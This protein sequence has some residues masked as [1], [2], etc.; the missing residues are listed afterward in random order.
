[1]SSR[2]PN[3]DRGFRHEINALRAIAVVAVIGFH[4]W[5]NL[6][7]GGYA[8][9]DVFFVISGYLITS[10]IVRQLDDGAFSFLDFYQRRIRRIFP[11]ALFVLVIITVVVLFITSPLEWADFAG[12]ISASALFVENWLLSILSV[13]YLASSASPSPVE[14]YWSLSVEEQ[15]YLLWPAFLVV[16][17]WICAKTRSTTRTRVVILATVIAISLLYSIFL[18]HSDPAPGYF[19]TF[20]RVWEFACGA[21]LSVVLTRRQLSRGAAVTVGLTGWAL[22]LSSFWVLSAEIPFPGVAALLPVGGALLVAA[23]GTPSSESVWSRAYANPVV[24][25]VAT[26]S[27]AAYLWHWPLLIFTADVIDGP[28]NNLLL[29]AMFA[30]T[31]LLAWLTTRFVENPLRFRPARSGVRRNRTMTVGV[32][33]ALMVAAVGTIPLILVNVKAVDLSGMGA[34]V[35]TTDASSISNG[36]QLCVG[37]Q[38]LDAQADCTDGPYPV[39][40]PNPLDPDRGFGPAIDDGCATTRDEDVYPVCTFGNPASKIRVAYVGDSHAITMFPAIE[41][42]AIAN[43]W[44]L[45]VFLRGRCSWRTPTGNS[46]T[47]DKFRQMVQTSLTTGEPWTAVIT[48]ATRG[49][50]SKKAEDY[51]DVWKPVMARGTQVVVIEDNPHTTD[52]A[53]E[54]VVTN[55]ADARSC[56]DPRDIAIERDP[57]F[58]AATSTHGVATVS[59]SDYFC[60]PDSCPTMIGGYVVYL[61]GN[62][63]NYQY[64]ETLAPYLARELATVT[65]DLIASSPSN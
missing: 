17:A 61:D 34:A 22:L 51:R 42:L 7:P 12:Q 26:V 20:G 25:F 8:G 53:R 46:D 63:L 39:L 47:C 29:V 5:P 18:V 3:A 56:A 4:F 60:R 32:V 57:Q 43:D 33:A 59:L 55:I 54:C 11:A 45:T 35:S 62:H 2:L 52:S 65:K 48:M 15:F 21:L 28:P 16:T 44:N 19:N 9:V 64:S 41:Q 49:A 31:L 23:A 13:D 6:I 58:A 50:A 24:M 40:T 10:Q 1:M 37:A 14:H 27:F 30:A 36:S 38:A